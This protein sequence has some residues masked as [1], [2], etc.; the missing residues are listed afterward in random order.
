MKKTLAIIIAAALML[1]MFVIPSFAEEPTRVDLWE[2]GVSVGV[3]TGNTDGRSNTH[4]MAFNAADDFVAIG[5]PQYWN[6]NGSNAPLVTYVVELF[7]YDTDYATSVTGTPVFT[8]TVNPEGDSATGIRFD[9][10]KT[11]PKGAYALRFTVT[12]EAGYMVLPAAKTPYS[13][14]RLYFTDSIFAIYIDFVNSGLSSYLKKLP[15]AGEEIITTDVFS[16]EGNDPHGVQEGAIAFKLNVPEGYALRAIVGLGSPTWSNPGGGSNCQA[17]VYAWKGD[18]DDSVDG[19]VLATAEVIDHADNADAVFTFDKDLPAGD[20]L[21]EF[22]QTGDMSFGFWCYNTTDGEYEVFLN[23][24]EAAFYPKTSVKLLIVDAEEEPA[25]VVC[26]GASFDSFFVNDVL[27]FN[28]GDGAA[29]S[30]LDNH[31]RT[32]DGSDG[33]VTTIILR[34]W[35]GFEGQGIDQFG[36]KVGDADPVFADGN[37][38][39]RGDIGAIRDPGNGG[40]FADAF[41]IVIDT[42]EIKGTKTIVAA[43]KLADG[44]I[45]IINEDIPKNGAGTTPNTSFTFIGVE[46]EQPTTE[47]ET[48]VPTEPETNTQTGDFTVAMFAVIA[49]LAMGAAVVFMKKRSF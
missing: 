18:Y 46:D 28:E 32:V 11:M 12:S 45:V 40:E 43:A 31:D 44:T 48:Q 39:E 4:G 16:G 5:I 7:N 29:S 42:S 24:N 38:E 41:K 35:I 36:Y 19:D 9:L 26:H 17:D 37:K 20:Y 23:G 49:V 1:T 22:T 14:A 8:Q 10:G 27:N 33:S 25:G 13:S 21:V 6:S 15:G 2:G 34:G 47:P 30:H 3:W